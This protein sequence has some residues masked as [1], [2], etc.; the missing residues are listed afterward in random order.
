[1]RRFATGDSISALRREEACAIEER[2]RG[3]ARVAEAGQTGG[4]PVVAV[5]PGG[6]DPGLVGAGSAASHGGKQERESAAVSGEPTQQSANGGIAAGHAA[7]AQALST[8]Q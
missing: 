6:S 2:V 5:P 1:M 3:G 7:R 4:E 8:A